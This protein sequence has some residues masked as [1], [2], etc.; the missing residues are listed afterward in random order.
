MSTDSKFERACPHCTGELARPAAGLGLY[1]V[2]S[3]FEASIEHQRDCPARLRTAR[4]RRLAA[5]FLGASLCAFS[6]PGCQV[7]VP[8]NHGAFGL[9]NGTV[10]MSELES[11]SDLDAA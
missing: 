4:L 9:D 10:G 1:A 11:D 6:V 5:G 3:P 8:N 7:Q 2:D